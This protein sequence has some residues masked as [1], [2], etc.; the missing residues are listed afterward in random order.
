MK[1]TFRMEDAWGDD[2]VL[3]IIADT[4]QAARKVAN[5]IDDDA[6]AGKLLKKE[7]T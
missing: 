1:F 6:V 3:S 5:N 2:Y 4:E 7:P